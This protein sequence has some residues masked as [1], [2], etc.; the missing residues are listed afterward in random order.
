MTVRLCVECGKQ[1]V[2]YGVIPMRFKVAA[3]CRF[4]HLAAVIVAERVG[5]V[6]RMRP[7]SWDGQ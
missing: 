1:R 7:R 4:G 3:N 5:I 6:L 2:S